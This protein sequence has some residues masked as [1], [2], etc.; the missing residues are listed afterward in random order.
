MRVQLAPKSTFLAALAVAAGGFLSAQTRAPEDQPKYRIQGAEVRLPS[1]NRTS[2]AE[3][4]GIERGDS[5]FRART[6]VLAGRAAPAK[7]DVDALR[8]RRLATYGDTAALP[9]APAGESTPVD[10]TGAVDLMAPSLDPQASVRLRLQS[11]R[12]VTMSIGALL[13]GV[14]IVITMRLRR[15]DRQRAP[16]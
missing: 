10:M 1:E 13:L 8:Q 3:L 7:V 2:A 11:F 9:S 4:I 14:A 5:D 12:I 15:S 6:P 16:A